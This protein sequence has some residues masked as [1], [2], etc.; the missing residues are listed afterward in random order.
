[1][2]FWLLIWLSVVAHAL[3]AQTFKVEYNKQKSLSY[4]RTF[5][6]NKGD[7][8]V[9]KAQKIIPDTTLHRWIHTALSG[10]L[11]SFQLTQQDAADVIVT[12]YFAIEARTNYQVL[13]PLAQ[14]PGKGIEEMHT[15]DYQQSTFIIDL[16]DRSGNLIWR[17]SSTNNLTAPLSQKLI[18]AIVER[19]FRK[20]KKMQRPKK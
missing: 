8:I 1:M 19:G 13:G 5:Q 9:S 11:I 6:I 20:F 16:N 17:V 18:E 7:V 10:K 14:T 15:F 2:R 3:A 12:Y 4:I